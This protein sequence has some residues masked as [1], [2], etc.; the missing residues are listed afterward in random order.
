LLKS[1]LERTASSE[2]ASGRETPR[3]GA[4]VISLRA[5]KSTRTRRCG[6]V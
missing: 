2:K 3:L 5:C 1:G 4:A 6:E